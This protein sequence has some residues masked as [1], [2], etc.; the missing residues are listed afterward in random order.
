MYIFSV[1]SFFLWLRCS[2]ASNVHGHSFYG[3][4]VFR[5]P[6]CTSSSTSA[7]ACIYKR[8]IRMYIICYTQNTRF[9]A[10]HSQC[11]GEKLLT[12]RE[13]ASVAWRVRVNDVIR[14]TTIL[15]MKCSIMW[16]A[17]FLLPKSM[18]VSYIV[19]RT[20]VYYRLSW[21]IL[22]LKMSKIVWTFNNRAFDLYF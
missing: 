10:V 19:E 17:F 13:V 6:G 9:C 2:S 21:S 7:C 20:C 15:A 1:S 22:V 8:Y 5:A 14:S 11:C 18:D 3:W 4:P 12:G 16:P